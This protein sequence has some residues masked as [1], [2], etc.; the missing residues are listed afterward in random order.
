LAS[1]GD[2]VHGARPVPSVPVDELPSYKPEARFFDGPTLREIRRIKQEMFNLV[3][4]R[5]EAFGG[6]SV[7]KRFDDPSIGYLNP[8]ANWWTTWERHR[9]PLESLIRG[10]DP[11]SP[12][13]FNVTF[14][15][16]GA[17]IPVF[18]Y[19]AP[20]APSYRRTLP[21]S[22]PDAPLSHRPPLRSRQPAGAHRSFAADIL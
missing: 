1:T 6:E 2:V 5:V 12:L 21:A 8:S 18:E 15:N 17:A 22:S 19:A 7:P 3:V 10:F 16:L 20:A 11:W 4:E 14:G 9:E 13:P